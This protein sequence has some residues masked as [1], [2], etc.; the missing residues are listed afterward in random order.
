MTF[1][2]NVLTLTSASPVDLEDM[3]AELEVAFSNKIPVDVRE[4]GYSSIRKALHKAFADGS[5]RLWAACGVSRIPR[6]EDRCVRRRLSSIGL[7]KSETNTPT[8]HSESVLLTTTKE[9]EFLA[10]SLSTTPSGYEDRIAGK[11]DA[12]RLMRKKGKWVE[13]DDEYED[14][15]E[16]AGVL[17]RLCARKWRR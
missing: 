17:K 7:D 5:E 13:D 2:T 6:E 14:A 15:C 10:Q 12:L 3:V 11:V 8:Q 9:L 1:T 16:V 4:E